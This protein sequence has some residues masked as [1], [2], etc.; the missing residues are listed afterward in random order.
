MAKAAQKDQAPKLTLRERVWNF[1]HSTPKCTEARVASGL[2]ITPKQAMKELWELKVRNQVTFTT[3]AIYPVGK[4]TEMVRFYFTPPGM[5]QW[6][7]VPYPSGNWRRVTTTTTEKK[8][9]PVEPTEVVLGTVHKSQ[10]STW[11]ADELTMPGSRK[12]L[13]RK[14]PQELVDDLTIAEAKELQQI[15]NNLLK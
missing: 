3:E 12:S 7:S 1:V 6:E 5:L 14:T 4:K 13:V 2:G 10:G 11:T 9:L 15:L 8:T